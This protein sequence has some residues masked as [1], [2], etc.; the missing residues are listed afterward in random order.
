VKNPRIEWLRLW[1]FVEG[2]PEADAAWQQKQSFD[3][4]RAPMV[5][6]DHIDAVVSHADGKTYESKS[7][8]FRSYRADG[9]PQGIRYECVGERVA[10]PYKRPQ[11][12]RNKA[13][14][15]VTRT[16]QQMGL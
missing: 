10:E 6:S 15:A 13:R 1:G 7:A 4:C 11:A 2:T 3:A 5:I 12:D 8:L 16:L 9:N 14:D